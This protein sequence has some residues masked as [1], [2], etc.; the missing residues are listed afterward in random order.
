MS[1]FGFN[2]EE[3]VR[4]MF[5]TGLNEVG[6]ALDEAIQLDPELAN[7]IFND[8]DVGAAIAARA[9]G[10]PAN[11]I[12]ALVSSL[13]TTNDVNS[14]FALT[15]AMLTRGPDKTKPNSA[16][17]LYAT[18]AGVECVAYPDL[19]ARSYDLMPRAHGVLDDKAI[20]FDNDTILVRVMAHEACTVRNF[21]LVGGG[22][23][24]TDRLSP[25]R[26]DTSFVSLQPDVPWDETPWVSLRYARP[27]EKTSFLFRVYLDEP[28][29]S[30]SVFPGLVVH[31]QEAGCMPMWRK[32][33]QAQPAD[34]ATIANA[35]GQ[36]A[37]QRTRLV[38]PQAKA[39]NPLSN[40]LNNKLR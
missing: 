37:Q 31:Y 14:R 32:W 5:G 1:S 28:T 24:E 20:S 18:N 11:Q 19:P 4:D 33:N 7:I 8:G 34:P 35:L 16:A 23:F 22:G 3:Y 40:V 25:F 26:K 10:V 6:A 2:L 30:T 9:P 17:T 12:Q 38:L 39:F 21:V 15:A 13:K 27:K 29:G 36:Y